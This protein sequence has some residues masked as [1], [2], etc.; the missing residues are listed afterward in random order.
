MHKRILVIISI[1]IF[2]GLLLS[3]C[4]S[5]TFTVTFDVDGQV[6]LTQEV[7]K[8]KSA[9]MPTVPTKTGYT[10]DNWYFDKDVWTQP[11]KADTKIINDVT[12]YAHWVQ[13]VV[14]V[15]NSYT[16]IF[17]SRGGS[18]VPGLR[19]KEGQAFVM[20]NNPTLKDYNFDGWY[21]DTACTIPFT[22]DY[23]ITKNIT[24]Y[25]KWVAVDSTTYFIRTGSTITGITDAGKLASTIVLPESLNGVKITALGDN[26]FDGNTNLKSISFPA[27]SSYTTIGKETFKGC[28]A[29][30]EVKFING[31]TTMGEG[32]FMNCTS[33]VSVNLPT[34]LTTI[35]KNLF[36]G[37]TSLK[38]ANLQYVKVDAIGEGAYS[39]CKNLLGPIKIYS[40]IKSVGA[41]AFYGCGQ[42]SNFVIEDGVESIG[43]KAFYN[44]S[45]IT[46]ANVPDTVTAL[47][48]HVFYNCASITS[49]YLGSGVTSI[50]KYTFYNAVKLD[51]I[52]IAEDAEI[53]SIGESA[54]QQC[55]ELENF[56]IPSG[57]T[58][59]GKSAFSG[60]KDIT[61]FV[62]P[63][64]VTKIEAQTFMSAIKLTTVTLH[65]DL[66]EIGTASFM[67]C[68]ELTTLKGT[69]GATTDAL[70]GVTTIGASVFS[71][72]KKLDNVTIPAGL[73][74]VKDSAFEDCI[75]LKNI[76]ISDGVTSIDRLA[77]SG[78]T[79]LEEIT[80]PSTLLSIGEYAF[81]GCVKL[82]NV[83]LNK[84]L[85]TLSATAFEN[86]SALTNITVDTANLYFEA[87][88]GAIYSKGKGTLMFYSDALEQ[89]E[90]TIPNGVKVIA[91]SVFKGN[92]TITK[93]ILPATMEE[94]G[95][96][97]FNG[98]R[99]LMEV[100]FPLNLKIIGASAFSS[101]KITT[102]PLPIGL[103][104][105]GQKA[106]SSSSLKS[107][108][109]PITLLDVSKDVFYGTAVG[110]N[111]TV[112]GD[113]GGLSGWSGAWDS[114][115]STHNYNV[116]Y[117]GGRVTSQDGQYQYILRDGRAVL[118]AFKGV[119]PEVTD[120]D[121]EYVY[122]VTVPATIDGHS[123]YALYKTFNGNNKITS[124]TI[125]S[126][127]ELISEMTFKGMTSLKEISLPFA[128]AYRGATGAGG[129]FGYA[130]DYSEDS[131]VGFVE[132]YA[133]GGARSK[134][135]VEIPTSL[136]KVTLTDCEIIAYGAFSNL[137][138]ITDVVLPSNV[139][140]IK[141]K[142]FYHCSLTTVVLP[143]SLTVIEK[144][145]FTYN[146]NKYQVPDNA[147]PPTVTFN[148][149]ASERPEGWVDGCF[150]KASVVNFV[151]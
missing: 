133:E 78:C 101:T 36:K 69:S 47:G 38:Y 70:A 131:K 115:M 7:T 86:C 59:I 144:E 146:Y 68:G 32:A 20:P 79:S 129:L 10:F 56:D 143:L 118:T 111:I 141:G 135:Y 39:G 73:K 46:T 25:A 121:A 62:L 60:C 136:H 98:C 122:E 130:F 93:V 14:P 117:G 42:V 128:G 12:V 24:V 105:L 137:H 75:G 107:V 123:V 45:K 30:S 91:H 23:K 102:A 26:L 43:D 134:Y 64:G 103:H 126:S 22:T 76:V 108:I 81:D 114:Q 65:K 51:K 41:E 151:F 1:L 49:A 50:P 147:N 63:L 97:A 11:L 94:I 4:N 71:A 17:D 124:L 148:A 16:I 92:E 142:A 74:V 29:L 58:S 3:A 2:A 90:V 8:G 82:N 77:F 6:Y 61:T 55:D 87:E 89:T 110:L 48:T 127:I 72:C 34:E 85:E 96:E 84:T 5:P 149:E 140:T 119:A 19:I 95:D 150:D 113:E 99:N 54:F 15:P 66:T 18:E 31:I 139:T 28:K 27:G 100:N 35:S 13:N 52:T 37:C 83:V 132:Q 120:P 67:N 125:P 109:M 138:N 88:N 106:F 9:T 53:T 116:T 112:E 80:L 145:A 104:T 40:D 57:V 21:L 33:L 44:C